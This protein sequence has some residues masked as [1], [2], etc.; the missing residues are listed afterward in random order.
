MTP[1]PGR[2]AW[3]EIGL[4]TGLL[5]VFNAGP[6]VSE[7]FLVTH[8]TAQFFQFFTY[9]YNH[10]TASHEPP[11][12][13]SWGPKA[14]AGNIM[15]LV[16]LAPAQYVTLFAGALVRADDVRR[17]FHVSM[18]LEQLVML[19][20]V[21][22]LSRRWYAW[23]ATRLFV[24]VAFIG[25]VYFWTQAGWNHRLYYLYP[26]T[27]LAL[28]R[29]VDTRQLAHLALVGFLIVLSLLGQAPYTLPLHL[30]AHAL[31]FAG[32]LVFDANARRGP[33]LRSLLAPRFAALSALTVGF[34]AAY[35]TFFRQAGEFANTYYTD[36]DP[37]TGHSTLSTFLMYG[38]PQPEAYLELLYGIPHD[39]D[40]NVVFY[41]GLIVLSLAVISVVSARSSTVN[42]LLATTV[43]LAA[44]SLGTVGVVAIVL[45]YG[46][47]L[48]K[49]FRHVGYVVC[50]VKFFLLL[51]AGFG[52]DRLLDAR[53]V[54]A[55]VRRAFPIA[56][57]MIAAGVAGAIFADP[58]R[59]VIPEGPR[60]IVFHLFALSL[61]GLFAAQ[62]W[63]GRE[64]GPAFHGAL[65]VALCAL[66]LAA[67]QAVMFAA[68]PVHTTRA[69]TAAWS[70]RV[71]AFQ[72]FRVRDRSEHRDAAL[73]EA[74]LGGFGQKF[75]TLDAALEI[76]SCWGRLPTGLSME[77][78]R[79][80]QG[81]RGVD[82]LIAA[83]LGLPID[84]PFSNVH[85]PIEDEDDYVLTA[86][87]GCGGRKVRF[88]RA[89]IVVTELA[90]AVARVRQGMALDY[91]PVLLGH[92]P[93]AAARV[94]DET[95]VLRPPA[96]Q[97]RVEHY[98][99]DHVV[100]SVSVDDD[101]A[102][103]VVKEPVHP[104]WRAS[105]DGRDQP[106]LAANLAFRAVWLDRG[107]HRVEFF[108][109]DRASRIAGWVL[110]SVGMTSIAALVV[111]G[112]RPIRAPLR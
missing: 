96:A 46:F 69:V 58:A 23:P 105:V 14:T 55:P 70:R 36:R 97:A 74:L 110:M 11:L 102:W 41:T 15:Q 92:A 104:R 94:T 31:L 62:L 89:G 61:L 90:D 112:L 100:F 66:E 1:P 20:G 71:P 43:V 18:V 88:Y 8:D 73:F 86:A 33:E 19:V 54:R 80:D 75:S 59:V 72:E 24:G 95:V 67:Y 85:E 48:M 26:F 47:P 65:A 108:Y 109:E 38:N 44:F 56:L 52:L 49:L 13:L 4:L 82:R 53:H 76:D 5:L 37:A 7:T 57:G 10:L 6:F 106:V 12:W 40:L 29:Y 87:L 91:V 39:A 107:R 28:V 99:A 17:L 79:R 83:R 3:W 101:G 35:A 16:T 77:R 32:F 84:G 51:L 103:M 93:A 25:T 98:G 30:L 78:L 21:W 34:G 45:Y 42:A 50:L 68:L 9:F 60:F 111:V 2:R 64:R 27:V 22:R 63:F 81:N